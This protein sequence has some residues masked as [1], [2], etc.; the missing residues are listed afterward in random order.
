MKLITTKK[1]YKN[2]IPIP[3]KWIGVF[4]ML[5]IILVWIS[6]FLWSKITISIL[7]LIIIIFNAMGRK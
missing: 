5:T 2:S 4:A 3:H 7:A 1:S 6:Q